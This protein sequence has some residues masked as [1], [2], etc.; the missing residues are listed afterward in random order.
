MTHRHT[1]AFSILADLRM[2]AFALSLL[3]FCY[4]AHPC[5]LQ[6]TVI[7][8][9]CTNF[10]CLL[11]DTASPI[12]V[13]G[14]VTIVALAEE[15]CSAGESTT[16]LRLSQQSLEQL[17]CATRKYPHIQ[18]LH[19]YHVSLHFSQFEDIGNLPNLRHIALLGVKSAEEAAEAA[20]QPLLEGHRGTGER[21]SAFQFLCKLTSLELSGQDSWTPVTQDEFQ[22]ISHLTNLKQIAIKHV[23]HNFSP[24][25]LLNKLSALTFLEI[26][27]LEHGISQ[28]TRLQSL[29]LRSSYKLVPFPVTLSGLQA[30][31]SLA[32]TINQACSDGYTYSAEQGI[33]DLKSVEVTSNL[34]KLILTDRIG[35]ATFRMHSDAANRS[36]LTKLWEEVAGFTSVKHL[37]VKDVRHTHGAFANLAKMTQ[38][39]CL[40]FSLKGYVNL[41]TLDQQLA[42]LSTLTSLDI[43]RCQFC[44]CMRPSDPWGHVLWL[45]QHRSFFERIGR[46]CLVWD[47]NSGFITCDDVDLPE[48][49]RRN[50]GNI[51]KAV[52]LQANSMSVFHVQAKRLRSCYTISGHSV[53]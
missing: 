30:L 50:V 40:D 42:T 34:Q 39:T 16:T 24:Y 10:D 38:L 52:L 15:Q 19:L 20:G 1:S 4:A 23:H 36:V 46:L 41:N 37:D 48:E 14:T 6:Y 53:T 21:P 26:N 27:K 5:V 13:A 47:I 11:R 44:C 32:F 3:S 35:V 51:L 33:Q 12:A 43:L 18:S 29:S 25:S 7:T 31:T 8:T 9:V 28:L 45:S 49:S 22:G 2:T 17:C